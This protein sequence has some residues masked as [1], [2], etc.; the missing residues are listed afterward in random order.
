MSAGPRRDRGRRRAGIAGALAAAVAL[1]IT[2][3]V[4]GAS[5]AVPSLVLVVGQAVIR[6]TPGELSRQGIESLG[7]TD[8]PALVA[9][10]VIVSVLA[11]VA[12]G[13]AA[14]GRRWTAPVGMAAFALVG[15]LAARSA[16]AVSVQGAATAAVLA[17]VGGTVALLALLRAGD[18]A[19]AADRPSDA[20]PDARTDAPDEPTGEPS[21]LITGDDI[22][23]GRPA[24]RF[25]TRPGG[26][27]ADPVIAVAATRRR[28]LLS[29][30]MA[31]GASVALL[32]GGRALARRS[33][34]SEQRAGLVL[35]RPASRAGGAPG[36]LDVDG[37]ST[38]LTPNDEFYRIDEALIVPRVDLDRWRLRVTGMVDNPLELTMDEL[39]TLPLV[40]RDITLACVSNPVGGPLIGNAR[41]LGVPL[42]RLLERAGMQRGASQIVGRSVDG[43]TVG[44]PTE[45]ALDGRDAMVAVGMNGEPLPFAHGF[46]ARLVVPGLYGY[47]SAT[48]WLTEI[49]LTT[50][51]EFDA[52]WVRRGWAK[53]APIKI[54]SRIDVPRAGAD[55]S[56]GPRAIAGV[57]WAQRRGIDRVEVRVD[58]G[59]WQRAR[60]GPALSDDAWRQWLLDWEAAPGRRRIEVRATGG[61]GE[62]QTDERDAPFPDGATGLHSITVDVS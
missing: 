54:Q 38:L 36:G 62:V 51:G 6:A 32:G 20:H 18:V 15:V 4:D 23:D 45:V 59:A 12:L 16:P 56:A 57:A 1:S 10:V 61:D 35:P 22:G 33:V 21:P 29:S 50:L 53:E 43:F 31:A 24:T 49:E 11:G 13:R 42:A 48:K 60:L 8:K 5:T 55:V 19:A 30:A 17:A 47:V 34:A 37:L 3:A 40:E 44:F 28:F 9:G 2:V 39:V 26:G 41:W 58:E 46:P 14:R 52:Y 7:Q 25:D 27:G